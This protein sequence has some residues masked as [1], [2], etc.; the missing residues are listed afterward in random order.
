LVWFF[1][2]I[3]RLFIAFVDEN[4]YDL[5]HE[6]KTGGC[7]HHVEI[8]ILQKHAGVPLWYYSLMPGAGRGSGI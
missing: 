5:P 3:P 2:L 7:T 1:F 4:K 6:I 8:L